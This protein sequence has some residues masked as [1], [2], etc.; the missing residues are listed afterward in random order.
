MTMEEEP[1]V[2]ENE[3]ELARIGFWEFDIASGK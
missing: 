1:K 2:Y 3:T